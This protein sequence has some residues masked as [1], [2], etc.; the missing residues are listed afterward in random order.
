MELADSDGAESGAEEGVEEERDDDD[1]DAEM[2]GICQ[3]RRER[4]R[5][6]GGGRRTGT[7]LS[8]SSCFSSYEGRNCRYFCHFPN[9][10]VDKLRWRTSSL[11]GDSSLSALVKCQKMS[12]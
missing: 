10:R 5:G 8:G 1:D 4:E 7:A 11:P 2:C 12:S 6:G 3:E 9:G